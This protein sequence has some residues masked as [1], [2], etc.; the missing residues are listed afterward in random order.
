MIVSSSRIIRAAGLSDP[1][2]L[3]P[4]QRLLDDDRLVFGLLAP[5]RAA[6]RADHAAGERE[7]VEIAADRHGRDAE[8]RRQLAHGGPLARLDE[9]VDPGAPLLEEERRAHGGRAPRL[10][11]P[12]VGFSFDFVRLRMLS[13]YSR[14]RAQ[15]L[16]RTRG[17]DTAARMRSGNPDRR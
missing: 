8:A 1:K 2:L 11:V 3:V 5:Q 17:R 14:L 4:V 13:S 15:P 9:L 10:A 7:R 6:V 16:S 12:A